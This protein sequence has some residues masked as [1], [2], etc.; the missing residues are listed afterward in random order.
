MV[1]R[2]CVA[3]AVGLLLAGSVMASA[4]PKQPLHPEQTHFTAEDAAVKL[5]V[6][7]PPEV[8]AQLARDSL[9]RNEM[10]NADPPQ[11]QPPAS[12]FSASV[13][14]L[15]GQGEKDLVVQAVGQLAGANVD[16][17]W[18]FR[19]LPGGPQLVLNGPAHDLIV[20][21][22]RWKGLRVIELDSMTA[23]KLNTIV[24]RFDG[25]RYAVFGDR[26]EEIK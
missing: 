22:T 17:F 5:P 11:K 4:Q 23:I 16:V 2:S 1:L 21:R 13:V 7:I 18:V 15:A 20:R 9:V 26:L 8:M 3:V 24:L 10:E 6:T 14:H 25:A 19:M 12:W